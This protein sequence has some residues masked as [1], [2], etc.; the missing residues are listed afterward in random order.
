M[1]AK[2][3]IIFLIVAVVL[4]ASA[5]W[6]ANRWM[7]READIRAGRRIVTVPVVV[8][9]TDV[10]AGQKLE[11]AHVGVQQWPRT[12]LPIGR[13]ARIKDVIGRVAAGPMVRGEAVVAGKLASKGHDA[14]L[15]AVVPE[16]YRALTVAVDEVIGVG[17]FVQAGDRVDVLVTMLAGQ[18]REDPVT[19]TVLIDVPV[20]TVGQ[21]VQKTSDKR[22]RAKANRVKV[23][24]LQVT[25]QQSEKLALGATVGKVLLSLRNK[26]DNPDTVAAVDPKR[27]DRLKAKTSGVYLTKLIPPANKPVRAVSR[28]APRSKSQPKAKS[29]PQPT[30]PTVEVIKGVA[31]SVQAL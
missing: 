31:R 21:K 16:G 28:P 6:G 10:E 20:L 30:G 26:A 2:G 4:A 12:S 7:Q 5:A 19:K 8:M 3:P 13:V 27:A 15:S 17:G 18:Y 22:G 11:A 23:V 1:R 29:A 24:T 14:G 9:R 25:P